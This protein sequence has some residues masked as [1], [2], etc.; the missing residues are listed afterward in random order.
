MQNILP[1][2]VLH[3]TA[4]GW[5]A[6]NYQKRLADCGPAILDFMNWHPAGAP[7]WRYLDRTK[8]ETTL[9]LLDKQDSGTHWDNH[10]QIILC[11]QLRIAHF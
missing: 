2:P 10:F 6:L 4:K 3:R 1:E 7:V 9:Q 11:H 8:V 5:F